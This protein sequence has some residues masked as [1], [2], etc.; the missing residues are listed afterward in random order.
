MTSVVQATALTT[1][2][3]CPSCPSSMAPSPMEVTRQFQPVSTCV[4]SSCEE[5]DSKCS[6]TTSCSNYEYVSTV[7][8]VHASG[9]TGSTKV[10]SASQ[11]VTFANYHATITSTS[12]ARPSPAV[13]YGNSTQSHQTEVHTIQHMCPYHEMGP[14]AM[15]GYGGSGVCDECESEDSGAPQQIVTVRDCVNA[16]CSSHIETW[17]STRG[18]VTTVVATTAP[19]TVT[20]TASNDAQSTATAAACDSYVL[21]MFR[22]NTALLKA[23]LGYVKFSG[24]DALQVTSAKEAVPLTLQGGQL[25]THDGM[26]IGTTISGF[27][28]LEKFSTIPKTSAKWSLTSPG[29][30]IKYSD[31]SFSMA[32]GSASFCLGSDYTVFGQYTSAAPKCKPIKLVA[33]C[34]KSDMQRTI[35]DGSML[36][37][38]N[39]SI[40][41]KQ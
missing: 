15:S 34:G 20:A 8:P 27:A 9:T 24:N 40:I 39:S 13:P 16:K 25:V 3:P 35:F 10:T 26:Y 7:C 2:T 22:A 41:F 33:Q 5:G 28:V 6:V 12:T 38:R 37:F 31:A 32:D 19:A 11:V 17:V 21:Q 29:S 1:V 14:I 30:E 18:S 23:P 36:T 4:P